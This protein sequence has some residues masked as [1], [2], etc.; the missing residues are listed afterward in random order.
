MEMINENKKYVIRP[1]R[2]VGT[3]KISGAKNSALRLLAA[4]ILTDKRIELNNYP[5]GLL[6][7]Q[8]HVE[9]L[10][11]LGKKC[12]VKKEKITITEPYKI[13]NRLEW[14]DRSIR[15]TLL[16]LGAL[17]TRTGYGAVPLPGGCNIGERKYDF[18]EMILKKMGAKIWTENNMLFAEVK[19]RLKGK[20]IYLPLRSTGATE[21]A[22]ICGCLAEGITKVWNP[23]IRPEILDLII[24][25]NKSGA[26]IN[27]YGSERIEIIGKKCLEG[28]NHRIIPD[29]LEAITWLIGA[30]ITGGNIKISEF[31]HEHL[32]V[33]LIY[34]RESGTKFSR[35]SNNL[36][37]NKGVCYPIDISTGPYPGINSDMQ[38]VFAVYALCSNGESRII[39]LRFPGR[40]NYVNELIKMGCK[41]EIKDNFLYI[42]GGIQ[43]YGAEVTATDLRA[44]A[45]LALAG[46]IAKGKTIVKNAWQIDRGYDCFY[47]KMLQLGADI[48]IEQ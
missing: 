38:P 19:D 31:P 11:K 45:A 12:E 25:L 8:I 4:S 43:L 47:E 24:F 40:Y 22:I 15:N 34:L 26:E 3:V 37:V 16:I 17:V 6:D 28:T 18:H 32:E 14:R 46:L 42:K 29:N 39:D 9:M 48:S 35:V 21:N 41:T 2:L 7:A 10:K 23:H 44:G 13:K 1:S 5:D 33:P 36:I 27:L 30:I 20:D